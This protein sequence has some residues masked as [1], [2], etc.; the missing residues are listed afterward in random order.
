[1]TTILFNWTLCTHCE[2]CAVGLLNV[3]AM[4]SEQCS[5]SLNIV[6]TMCKQHEQCAAHL[7]HNGCTLYPLFEQFINFTWAG[8]SSWVTIPCKFWMITNNLA[9][10]VT[11]VYTDALLVNLLNYVF[12]ILSYFMWI[13]LCHHQLSNTL[14]AHSIHFNTLITLK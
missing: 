8:K 10:S 13:L 7:L 5:H 4:C 12:D 6:W 11:F 1:M 9:H 14:C 3:R 2:Q